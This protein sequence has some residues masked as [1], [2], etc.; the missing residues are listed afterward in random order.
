MTELSC[1]CGDRLREILHATSGMSRAFIDYATAHGIDWDIAHAII[2]GSL[3]DLTAKLYV[4]GIDG[5]VSDE[6]LDL[7][8]QIAR[9]GVQA[10][11][12]MAGH[13]TLQ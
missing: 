11:S 4:L 10:A 5:R 9:S 2:V 6:Q 12:D 3:L 8:G 7:F 13:Q 1:G